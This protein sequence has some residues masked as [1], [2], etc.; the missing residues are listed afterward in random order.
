MATLVLLS[1]SVMAPLILAS[2]LEKREEKGASYKLTLLFLVL[3]LLQTSLS[4]QEKYRQ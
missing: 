1:V 3:T 4:M 2:K